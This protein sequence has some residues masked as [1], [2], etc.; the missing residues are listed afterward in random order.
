[1]KQ[2]IIY[3]LKGLLFSTLVMGLLVFLLAF[4]M[5][6]G[7]IGDSVMSA[8]LIVA[9]CLSTFTGAWYFAKHAEARRFLW[10]LG[11]GTAFFIIYLVLTISLSPDF[12]VQLERSLTM[13]AFALLSG[14][15]GG[16]LS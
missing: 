11:F 7:Q 9:L 13:L 5:L 15:V 16:M 6:K 3:L 14:C 12:S 4:V 1:M 2:N 10:G 8:L